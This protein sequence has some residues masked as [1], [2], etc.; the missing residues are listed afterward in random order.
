VDDL[1]LGISAAGHPFVHTDGKIGI[2]DE[3]ADEL[4]RLL[5]SSG[6]VRGRC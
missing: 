6:T 2:T 5:V 1:D 3:N 4:I